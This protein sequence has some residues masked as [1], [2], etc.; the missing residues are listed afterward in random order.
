MR[1]IRGPE[2]GVSP[3]L[4]ILL[5]KEDTLKFAIVDFESTELKGDKA[6]LLCGGIKPLGGKGQVI[7]IHQAG[8][9]ADRLTIDRKLV[10]ALRDEIEQYDGIITWNGIMFDVPLLNDRLIIA[11]ETILSPKFHID[12]MYQARQ[13]KSTFTSSRLDWVAKALKCPFK[14]TDLDLNLWKEAE[15]EALAHFGNGRV[16]YD[17]IVRHCAMDLRVT[18]W[19][20][21]KLKPRVRTI[22]RRG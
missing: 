21:G 9:G 18:E 11:G 19:V 13:G 16:N 15:A 2:A 22:S 5:T 8:F 20:Y 1:L 4:I 3:A 17:Y 10:V 14:K 6:F 7:G 12:I